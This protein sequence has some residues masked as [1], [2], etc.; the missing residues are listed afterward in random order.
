MTPRFYLFHIIKKQNKRTAQQ[1]TKQ[2]SC[3]PSKKIK[4]P[5]TKDL[6]TKKTPK[7]GYNIDTPQWKI[8]WICVSLLVSIPASWLF[9]TVQHDRMILHNDNT[10]VLVLWWACSDISFVPEVQDL[11]GQVQ[12]YT[13]IF[14]L[15]YDLGVNNL[16]DCTSLQ[17]AGDVYQGGACCAKPFYR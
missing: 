7:K 10:S 5:Q 14:G 6:K 16:Q 12:F 15:I 3:P 2:T 9:C 8:V 1:K 11:L 4:I 13:E 17:F